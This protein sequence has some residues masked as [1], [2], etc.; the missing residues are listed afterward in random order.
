M[1][2]SINRQ[3]YFYGSELIFATLAGRTPCE[4]WETGVGSWIK[5]FLYKLFFDDV[6]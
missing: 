5:L 6:S 2:V 3:L 4:G 1:R